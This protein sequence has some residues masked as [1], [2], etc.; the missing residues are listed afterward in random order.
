MGKRRW[1][2]EHAEDP[3]DMTPGDEAQ[4]ERGQRNARNDPAMRDGDS[5][6]GNPSEGGSQVQSTDNDV[7]DTAQT[8]EP[9]AGFSGGAVG[10]TPA[11]KRASGG[12]RRK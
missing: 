4:R 10:G 9:E 3:A 1:T 6:F 2:D 8:D 11:G 5:G 12:K 7:G